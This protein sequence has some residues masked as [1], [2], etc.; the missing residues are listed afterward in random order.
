MTEAIPVLSLCLIRVRLVLGFWL[1]YL[2]EP[3]LCWRLF[4]LMLKSSTAGKLRF[5][6]VVAR[7]RLKLLF[8]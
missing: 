5:G 1:N 2:R 7:L 6:A 4:R 8:K 3:I